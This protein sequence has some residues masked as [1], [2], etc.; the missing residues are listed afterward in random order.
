MTRGKDRNGGVLGDQVDMLGIKQPGVHTLFDAHQ[1]THEGSWGD[2]TEP[3]GQQ[4]YT[5]TTGSPNAFSWTAPPTTTS[6]CVVCV[7]GGGGGVRNPAGSANGG[8]A[9]GLAWKNDIPVVGGQ[10]YPGVA[11][12]G[13]SRSSTSNIGP[14]SD[15]ADS[16]FISPTTVCGK[17]GEGGVNSPQTN[18][19]EGGAFTGDG[20]GE[21]GTGEHSGPTRRCGG[22]GGAG[23]Y[24]GDG[25]TIGPPT[26]S[27]PPGGGGAAGGRG[28]PGDRGGGGGGVGL[29]GEGTSGT[30]PN[31]FPGGDGIHGEGGSGGTDGGPNGAS[32]TNRGNGGL[33]GGGGAGADGPTEHGDG[34]PGAVRIIWGTGRSFPTTLTDD[35]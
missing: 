5:A 25:G 29:L 16:Y 26:R 1:L 24:S 34:G 9:G 11:G 30:H 21:G 10:S 17:G 8:G 14:A 33:Y 22:G 31:G 12:G 20:G 3:A 32:P 6:V 35:Q 23:G 15:G 7:G 4:V 27:A 19:A 28:G 2:V 18:T 13:G